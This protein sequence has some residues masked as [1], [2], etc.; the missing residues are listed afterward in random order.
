MHVPQMTDRLIVLN[1]PHPRGL[2]RE[3]S[4]IP[5]QRFNSQYARNFQQEGT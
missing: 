5:Q 4:N 2:Q 3:L 1:L